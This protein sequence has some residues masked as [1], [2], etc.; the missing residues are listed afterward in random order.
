V[1]PADAANL[2]FYSAQQVTPLS[3][4]HNNI[5]ARSR[6]PVLSGGITLI[7]SCRRMSGKFADFRAARPVLRIVL[8]QL[9]EPL[10]MLVPSGE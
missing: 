3:L 10:G 1:L 2:I 7:R 5:M 8:S 4:V 9:G 6:L